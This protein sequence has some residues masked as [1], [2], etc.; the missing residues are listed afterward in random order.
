MSHPGVLAA[1][2]AAPGRRRVEGAA[3]CGGLPLPW[4]FKL[5]LF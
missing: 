5:L 4:E 1:G 2:T 3:G